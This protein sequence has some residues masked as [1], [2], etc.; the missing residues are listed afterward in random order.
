M[1]TIMKLRLDPLDRLFSMCYYVL[2]QYY[3][4]YMSNLNHLILSEKQYTARSIAT[5]TNKLFITNTVITK[6]LL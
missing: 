2:K 1:N 3:N 5:T 6:F 4:T